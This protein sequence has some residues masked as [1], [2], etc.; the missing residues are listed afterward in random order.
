MGVAVFFRQTHVIVIYFMA[1]TEETSSFE[2]FSLLMSQG[3]SSSSTSLEI[4]YIDRIV[5]RILKTVPSHGKT[6]IDQT[7][8]MSKPG[9]VLVM[10]EQPC[11]SRH[12][13]VPSKKKHIIGD[14]TPMIFEISKHVFGFWHLPF[15]SLPNRG[16]A[17]SGFG[18]LGSSSGARLGVGKNGDRSE[19]V[20]GLKTS[21]R[22]WGKHG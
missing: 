6:C 17:W 18:A 5:C 2:P 14:S 16:P 10:L 13:C 7:D 4:N 12:V 19:L 20:M 21:S 3:Q 8:F 22:I 11:F 1:A 15:Q 9:S